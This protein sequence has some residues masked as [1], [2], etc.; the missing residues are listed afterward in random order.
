MILVVDDDPAFL[1]AAERMFGREEPV[2]FA[3]DAEHA[4]ALM[5]TM[6]RACSVALVDLD[7]PRV[8]GLRLIQQL[9]DLSPGLPIIAISVGAPESAVAVGASEVLRKPIT[10]DWQGVIERHRAGA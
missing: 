9:R 6:G 7:L 5:S 1:T 10:P 8:D 3:R 4:L 2:Y